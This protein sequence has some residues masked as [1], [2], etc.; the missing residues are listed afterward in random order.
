MNLDNLSILSQE[1]DED[2]CGRCGTESLIRTEYEDPE[3]LKYPIR[4]Y[5]C[6]YCEWEYV[7]S[8]R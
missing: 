3:N 5:Y 6:E 2:P 4:H 8:E 1:I 7:E